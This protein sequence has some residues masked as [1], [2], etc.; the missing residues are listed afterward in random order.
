MQ[1]GV[2]I[3][4]LRY[5]GTIHNY[6]AKSNYRYSCSKRCNSSGFQYASRNI[7]KVKYILSFIY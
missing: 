2:P 6:D 5:L 4:A 7:F 3:T 1:A